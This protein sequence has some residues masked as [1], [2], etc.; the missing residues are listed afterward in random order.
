MARRS[1]SRSIS[2]PRRWQ[3][4]GARAR[5][6]GATADA[7]SAWCLSRRA[8]AARRDGA[9]ARVASGARGL[10]RGRAIARAARRSVYA[11]AVRPLGARISAIACGKARPAGDPLGIRFARLLLPPRRAR[12]RAEGERC[13]PACSSRR[14]RAAPVDGSLAPDSG[15][16][17]DRCSVGSLRCAGLDAVMMDTVSTRPP[18]RASGLA[19]APAR[20]RVSTLP[21]YVSDVGDFVLGFRTN[22]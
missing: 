11:S 13:C 18:D 5:L 20:L 4:D 21:A 17:S 3:G 15:L 22:A 2:R 8:L 1:V 12:S 7:L 19:G 16:P 10:P 9:R 14:P 6:D